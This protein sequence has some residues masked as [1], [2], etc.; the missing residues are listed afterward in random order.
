M[1]GPSLIYSLYTSSTGHKMLARHTQSALAT[2]LRSLARGMASYE[3]SSRPPR[4]GNDDAA[5]EPRRRYTNDRNSTPSSDRPHRPRTQ[6][7]D[8]KGP[9]TPRPHNGRPP[10]HLLTLADLSPEQISELLLSSL[11]YKH[12]CKAFSAQVVRTSLKG[13]TVAMLF[14]KRSTRTRVASETATSVLGG[15]AMFLGG[16][17]IQLGVNESLRD[18]AQVIGSMADGFMARV[19]DHREIE[20][21]LSFFTACSLLI[22]GTRAILVRPRRQRSLVPLAPHSDPRRPLDAVRSLRST[23]RPQGGRIPPR[24]GPDRPGQVHPDSRRPALGSQGQEDC[25][26]RRYE[27]HCL[28]VDG[29]CSEIRN[30][31]ERGDAGGVR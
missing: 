21:S 31:D 17:D 18:T 26:G 11:T 27:Q 28:G 23:P 16:A 29:D 3:Q 12:L 24:S 6:G 9:A 20:V 25:L 2:P 15:N 5:G 4:F 14:N 10:P 13:K 30:G 19:G 8:S 22:T 1:S 7:H